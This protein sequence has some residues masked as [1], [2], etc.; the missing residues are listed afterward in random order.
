MVAMRSIIS[1]SIFAAEA[2]TGNC[3]FNAISRHTSNNQSQL[4]NQNNNC[5]Q[6]QNNV[7]L[8]GVAHGG[9]P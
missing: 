7:V 6:Q 9:M 8:A 5:Q 1:R 4:N 3:L 2:F